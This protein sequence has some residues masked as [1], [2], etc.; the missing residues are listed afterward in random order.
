MLEDPY[1]SLNEMDGYF[2]LLWIFV[3]IIS[4]FA[5]VLWYSYIAR[6]KAKWREQ[7]SLDF[8]WQIL[9]GQEAERRRISQELH[10]TVLPAIR[11]KAVAQ[12]VREICYDL[13]PPDFSRLDLKDILSDLGGAFTRR[14]GI[15]FVPVFDSNLDFRCLSPERQLHLYR[16]VQ[17]AFTNI[18]KHSGAD[19]AV[20]TVRMRK[21]DGEF[22]MRISV[23]DNGAG[24]KRKQDKRGLGMRSMRERA[25]AMG[26]D[27]DF[28]SES[29]NGLMVRIEVPCAVS[30]S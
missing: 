27:I 22:S 29:G 14:T 4:A 12:R 20:L 21:A 24:L 5:V 13:M 6:R 8:S 19:Q 17:E 30:L 3:A 10:D 15:A 28:I 18:E 2:R 1:L 26:A 23:L 25:A 11:D 9:A 7:E 16:I